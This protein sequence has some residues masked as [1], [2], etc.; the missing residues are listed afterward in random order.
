MTHFQH[1][2]A[3]D[4][5][6]T[7]DYALT[8]ARGTNPRY[9]AGLG[10]EQGV[11]FTNADYLYAV[12][13]EMRQNAVL[14]ERA[15]LEEN[16]KYR[17][18]LPY[19]LL[20]P[21]APSSV[22]LADRKFVCYQRGQGV[23]ESRL[24][25]NYSIGAGGHIDF[26]DVIH[27]NSVIDISQTVLRSMIREIKEE[28]AFFENG[29]EI[30]DVSQLVLHVT[31]MLRPI[32]FIRD[33]SNAVGRV[34][35]GIVHLISYPPEWEV[36]TREAELEIQPLMSARELLASGWKFENWSKMLL[37][38]FTQDTQPKERW[39][40]PGMRQAL[41]HATDATVDDV[42]RTLNIPK[43]V[44]EY[45]NPQKRYLDEKGELRH[46]ALIHYP[47]LSTV[48]PVK[49]SKETSNEGKVEHPRRKKVV[50]E[51][52]STDPFVT[53]DNLRFVTRRLSIADAAKQYGLSIERFRQFNHI[54]AH[55]RDEDFI[56]P[57]VFLAVSVPEYYVNLTET[58]KELATRF[59][60]EVETIA[61]LNALRETFPDIPYDE[62]VGDYIVEGAIRLKTLRPV[63]EVKPQ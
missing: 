44:L 43:D 58:I 27:T 50:L 25:G 46:D 8:Q 15:S 48:M 24:A 45:Y 13:D 6:Y 35:L 61:Q 30:E 40:H 10:L 5:R 33:D 56:G 60:V 9:M 36:K 51:R 14:M 28:F 1:I 12:L 17:Q 39:A 22:P 55:L 2:L 63:S 29:V 34:H 38:S 32:G 59:D 16:P 19:T 57:N 49:I 4:A 42:C 62:L 11:T 3:V 53:N 18:L 20:S 31:T 47:D 26:E 21:W 54:G 37:E 41:A 52:E 23:G 7:N